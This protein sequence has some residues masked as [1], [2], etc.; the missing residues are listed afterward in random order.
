MI[1]LA[2]FEIEDWKYLSK[3]IKTEE[4]LVQFAGPIF[5][6]PINKVQVQNYLSAEQR[7][8]FKVIHEQYSTIGIAEICVENE[9]VAKL[10]RIL[11]GDNS[12]RGKGIGTRLIQQLVIYVFEK[13]NKQ[14]II[15]NV[16]S[17][18][19]SAIKC[20]EKV[21]FIKTDKAPTKITVGNKQ[22][23]VI[24]MERTK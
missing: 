14:R 19:S 1:D 22:W 2:P 16:F 10:A 3:W 17:W 23:E 24:E 4:E 15:L 6:F 13:L 18:N 9:R 21:G 8:V 12:M 5:N 20:Y 7:M 11:I